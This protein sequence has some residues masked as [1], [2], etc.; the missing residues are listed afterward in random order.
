[1]MLTSRQLVAMLLV[2]IGLSL[3]AFGGWYGRPIGGVMF[4]AVF[5][6]IAGRL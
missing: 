6:F 1:M 3:M 5:G 2:M 4:G